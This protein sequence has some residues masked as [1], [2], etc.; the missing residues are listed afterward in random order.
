MRGTD[1][2]ASP[3]ILSMWEGVGVKVIKY[4]IAWKAAFVVEVSRTDLI[5]VMFHSVSNVMKQYFMDGVMMISP[6]VFD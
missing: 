1:G 6:E 5:L 2:G 3:A 4:N